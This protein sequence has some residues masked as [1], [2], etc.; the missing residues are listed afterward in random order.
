MGHEVVGCGAVPVPLVRGRVDDV[1]R[2][3]VDDVATAGLHAAVALGD[4]E[5]LAERVG[6]PGGACTRR[7]VGRAHA[8]A[9]GWST[10]DDGID[11]DVSREPLGRTFGGRSPG[12]QLHDVSSSSRAGHA[13]VAVLPC[14]ASA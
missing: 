2:T 4:V 3:D 14:E 11:P 13:D 12:L 6:V 9:G 10:L 8:D 7:E 1:A 5:A